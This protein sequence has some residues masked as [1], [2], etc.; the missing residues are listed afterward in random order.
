MIASG[1]L[2]TWLGNYLAVCVMFLFIIFVARLD[3][4][5]VKQCTY[6]RALFCYCLLTFWL[7]KPGGPQLSTAKPARCVLCIFIMCFLF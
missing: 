6:N 2:V 7:R 4:T 5:L 3:V 1:M